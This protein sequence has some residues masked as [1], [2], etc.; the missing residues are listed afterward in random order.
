MF[1]FHNDI[2]N[3]E[4]Q[5]KACTKIL[6]QYEYYLISNEHA[7]VRVTFVQTEGNKRKK[8]IDRCLLRSYHCIQ[9]THNFHFSDGKSWVW[10][11]NHACMKINETPG[12]L[13]GRKQIMIMAI[14]SN[15]GRVYSFHKQI[16]KTFNFSREILITVSSFWSVP[17]ENPLTLSLSHVKTSW[18][19]MMQLYRHYSDKSRPVFG[20]PVWIRKFRRKLRVNVWWIDIHCTI[21]S[22]SICISVGKTKKNAI[23]LPSS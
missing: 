1:H 20:K 23:F 12:D 7:C 5:V 11:V 4:W 21:T 9:T 6:Y 17:W 14:K 3:T 2:I 15:L 10:A 8:I 16:I 22:W 19:M 13:L 18:I